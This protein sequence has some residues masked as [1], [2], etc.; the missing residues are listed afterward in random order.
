MKRY[1]SSKDGRN[2]CVCIEKAPK[3]LPVAPRPE[4]TER[5]KAGFLV[6]ALSVSDFPRQISPCVVTLHVKSAPARGI[7]VQESLG[8]YSSWPR[9][10]NPGA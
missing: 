6:F 10:Y 7:Q 4:V 5:K 2:R 8:R 1:S 3:H 9:K